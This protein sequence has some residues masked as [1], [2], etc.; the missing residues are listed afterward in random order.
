[1]ILKKVILSCLFL[2]IVYQ[3][4]Y[5]QGQVSQ[6]I[7]QMLT[8][9]Q[10]KDNTPSS[11]YIKLHTPNVEVK[12]TK[13]SRI[14]VTGKVKLGIPNLFFLDV[15][16]KKGRY[17]VFLIADG[18]SNLRVEDKARQHMVLRGEECKEDV[19]YTFYVPES[20]TSVVVENAETGESKAVSMEDKRRTNNTATASS[21]SDLPISKDDK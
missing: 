10:D 4:G 18:G 2:L 19:Y 17:S 11:I 13:G 20:I 15:L 12:Y 1:M 7:N 8:Y 3:Y 16:I 14:M 21:T 6:S 5:T 9:E